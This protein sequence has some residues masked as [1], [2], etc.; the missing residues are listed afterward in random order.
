[1]TNYFKPFFFEAVRPIP[2]DSNK[3]WSPGGDGELDGDVGAGNHVH[4]SVGESAQ[5]ILHKDGRR[6]AHFQSDD[7]ILWGDIDLNSGVL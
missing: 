6:L 7:S 4:I 5:N 3:T 2:V 1:M